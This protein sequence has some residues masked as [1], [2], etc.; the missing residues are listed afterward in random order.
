MGAQLATGDV[1]DR[2]SMRASMTGADIVVHSAG[3]YEFGVG[4]SG[5][6][7]MQAVN[8]VG[9]ENVLGLA[10]ELCVERTVYVSTV[11]A[12]GETGTHARD[13]TFT[14]Q[15]PSR[16]FYEQ[17]K[18]DAHEI[19]L[20]YR[21]HGLPLIIICP[22]SVVGVNDH[23]PWGYFLRLYVN[24]VMPPIAW[25]PNTMHALVYRDDVAEGI[26]LAAEKGR[27][28]E[29]YFLSGEVRSFREHLDFWTRKPGAFRPL[30]WL[31]ARLAGLLFAP[32]EPLQRVLGL[33][34]FISRETVLAASMNLYYSNEKAKRELGWSP[35]SAEAM[36]FAT[37]D[38][39]Q[40]LLPRRKGQSLI[41]RLKPLDIV[42]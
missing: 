42:D 15:V 36:W 28:D 23:S 26:A 31:P 35:R 32:L 19:A 10:H 16:T 40:E 3:H 29:M 18:T 30:I 11:V 24:R 20:R 37:I 39:E 22:N 2:E 33:P 38:G 6:Q 4:T 14:R 41:Q 25:S 17:S 12:F 27:I 1:T 34:A 21:Q 7:R 5:R 9:T 8:V 13:E